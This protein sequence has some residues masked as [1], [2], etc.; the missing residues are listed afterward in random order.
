M[1]SPLP[2]EHLDPRLRQLTGDALQFWGDPVAR[3]QTIRDI[4]DALLANDRLRLDSVIL[5]V[6]NA[7]TAGMRS[8][9]FTRDPVR[10]IRVQTTGGLGEKWPTCELDI[11]A[12][13]LQHALLVRH[14]PDRVVETW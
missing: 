1:P 12:A 14:Q 10:A 13:Q 3:E 6:D 7:V 8:L 4:L 11:D 9:G 5:A 2:F